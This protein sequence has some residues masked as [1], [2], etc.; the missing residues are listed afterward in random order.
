MKKCVHLVYCSQ[1]RG[2]RHVVCG[3]IVLSGD[4]AVLLFPNSGDRQIR[5]S[6]HVTNEIRKY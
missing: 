4:Q 6:A 1:R 3:R 2:S 5:P